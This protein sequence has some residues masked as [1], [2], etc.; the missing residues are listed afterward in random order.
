MIVGIDHVQLA[1]PEGS[2]DALR[3][4]Y[5]GLLG[6][7]EVPKPAALAK[8]GGAWFQGPGFQLHLGIE[9]AFRPALKAHPGM[10]VGDLDGLAEK[11]E[12]AGHAVVRDDLIPGCRR[13]FV[14]DP[15][16]NRLEFLKALSGV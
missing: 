2:E 12:K 5:D 14:S 4:F 3:A 10:L 6:L 11:L 16:G 1:A 7:T 15:V 9:D 8:R 13:F